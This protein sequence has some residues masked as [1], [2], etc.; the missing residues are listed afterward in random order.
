[1][2]FPW[3][4]LQAPYTSS[5]SV[6]IIVE[7]PKTV[8]HC[9]PVQ[10]IAK[11]KIIWKEIMFLTN[12]KSDKRCNRQGS[13]TS[14]HKDNQAPDGHS[15]LHSEWAFASL[16]LCSSSCYSCP[17]GPWICPALLPLSFQTF[18]P[19]WS[20]KQA[21]S[22]FPSDPTPFIAH[23]SCSGLA[24]VKKLKPLE[25]FCCYTE[26]SGQGIHAGSP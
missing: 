7:R 19:P 10:Q 17:L 8:I 26:L 2:T 15:I 9:I 3:P 14:F 18:L 20:S 24:L 12:P 23:P 22:S 6:Q 25:C 16:L 11:L 21:S 4:V 1:M 5:F 13:T